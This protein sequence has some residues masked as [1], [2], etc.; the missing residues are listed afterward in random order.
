M[1]SRPAKVTLAVELVAANYG[2]NPDDIYSRSRTQCVC[3]ARQ[4]AYWVCRQL[5]RPSYSLPEL[6][7]WFQR[8]H[9]TLIWGI[10]KFEAARELDMHLT[11][12]SNLIVTTIMTPDRFRVA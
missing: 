12:M 7:R 10:R 4:M 6:G 5:L 9:S 1:I 11:V 8:D 3:E 2:L